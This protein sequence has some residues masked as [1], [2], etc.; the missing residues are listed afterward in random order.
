MEVEH[1]KPGDTK[2]LEQ[3]GERHRR[4]RSTLLGCLDSG[5]SSSPRGEEQRQLRSTQVYHL[6]PMS[7]NPSSDLLVLEAGQPWRMRCLEVSINVL[8]SLAE[9]KTGPGPAWPKT[10]PGLGQRCFGV[11]YQLQGRPAVDRPQR[12][13]SKGQFF[14][15]PP[16]EKHARERR[17]ACLQHGKAEIESYRPLKAEAFRDGP[18]PPPRPTRQ[19][20]HGTLLRIE[21]AGE[22]CLL[23]SVAKRLT[24]VPGHDSHEVRAYHALV[25][26]DVS[27]GFHNRLTIA[28]RPS[29][30]RGEV[31]EPVAPRIR[32]PAPAT[33]DRISLDADW[34]AA[35]WA[36]PQVT[37]ANHGHVVPFLSGALDEKEG[38]SS[39]GSEDRGTDLRA[40]PIGFGSSIGPELLG[41]FDD[42]T[43]GVV[44]KSKHWLNMSHGLRASATLNRFM[45][46]DACPVLMKMRQQVG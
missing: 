42:V 9:G 22:V 14:G 44:L 8:L 32:A 19:V 27:A 18:G 28:R 37:R 43:A 35:I 21:E 4:H 10:A 46:Q 41:V 7:G 5:P 26:C 23:I 20:E 13:V 45:C 6:H 25:D 34:A 17:A 29:N 24:P 33:G 31:D 1:A 39:Q 36:C 2:L 30:L 40:C 15:G 12:S 3:A 11:R 16:H 38:F